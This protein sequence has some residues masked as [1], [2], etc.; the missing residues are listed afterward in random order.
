MSPP[1][2]ADDRAFKKKT[3]GAVATINGAVYQVKLLMWYL[4]HFYN[5]IKIDNKVNFRMYSEWK[6]AEQVDD[7]VLLYDEMKPKKVDGITLL[8]K[9]KTEEKVQ[10]TY[11]KATFMQLKYSAIKNK[12]PIS[13]ADLLDFRGYKKKNDDFVLRKYFQSFCK[14]KKNKI[15]DDMTIECI[16]VTN[17][18]LGPE[19]KIEFLIV[20]KKDLEGTVLKIPD[21]VVYKLKLKSPAS[22]FLKDLKDNLNDSP[23]SNT[24]AMKMY[25]AYANSQ[26]LAYT[27]QD[28]RS[29]K[30]FLSKHILEPIEGRKKYVR[31]RDGFINGSDAEEYSDVITEFR[32]II[33]DLFKTELKNIEFEASKYFYIK[34]VGQLEPEEI[35]FKFDENS[36][37]CFLE[38]LRIVK[39]PDEGKMDELITNEM[40]MQRFKKFQ[41][42]MAYDIIFKKMFDWYRN[43]TEGYLN[44]NEAESFLKVVDDAFEEYGWEKNVYINK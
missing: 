13:K 33:E 29:Y 28:F 9:D 41:T 15:F 42:D 36:I 3:Q 43:P 17:I 1:E 21:S 4:L 30:R 7:I 23:A 22:K 12:T 10:Q 35:P 5:I 34:N 20:E 44:F 40:T 32:K 6:E 18:D 11:T 27:D 2:N 19:V 8:G 31:F 39:T 38:A 25:K 37:E 24:L 26:K 16:V 14:I